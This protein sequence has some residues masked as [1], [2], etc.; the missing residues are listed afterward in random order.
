M[1]FVNQNLKVYSTHALTKYYNHHKKANKSPNPPNSVNF[2]SVH[3]VYCL[4]FKQYFM[5]NH[6]H[7]ILFRYVVRFTVKFLND[8]KRS[9]KD[10]QPSLVSIFKTV[11]PECIQIWLIQQSMPN[12]IMSLCNVQIQA[13]ITCESITVPRCS[14]F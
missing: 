6:K 8:W 13:A 11:V 2:V 10:L 12:N 14:N 7:L 3:T 9:A 4:L 5:L 1:C